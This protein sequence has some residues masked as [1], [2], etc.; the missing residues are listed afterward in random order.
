MTG[1]GSRAFVVK[2]GLDEQS[3]GVF[4]S[5]IDGMCKC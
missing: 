1:R 2:E 5:G 3:H 4:P